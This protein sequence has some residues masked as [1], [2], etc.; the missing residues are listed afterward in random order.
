MSPLLTYHVFITRPDDVE[1]LW[2][3][4]YDFNE[5]LGMVRFKIEVDLEKI[6]LNPAYQQVYRLITVTVEDDEGKTH[7]VLRYG[8]ESPE[9]ILDNRP[10]PEFEFLGSSG[11]QIRI[12][13]SR[14]PERGRFLRNTALTSVLG[15][16][17]LVNK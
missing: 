3:S 8:P 11:L 4:H 1:W 6:A 17:S 9:P 7:E 14:A 2:I 12:P 10:M 15:R 5:V 16:V 13:S